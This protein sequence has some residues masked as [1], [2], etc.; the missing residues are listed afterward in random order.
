MMDD[1]DRPKKLLA[2][3]IGMSLDDMSIEE[4]TARIEILKSEIERLEVAIK[5]KSASR[6]A[7][8]SFFKL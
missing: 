6:S 8:E 5:E 3:E 2:H 7:A 4:L 1:D